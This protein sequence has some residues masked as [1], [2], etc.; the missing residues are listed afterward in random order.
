M[1]TGRIIEL[2]CR[3]ERGGSKKDVG[4]VDHGTAVVA[5][6]LLVRR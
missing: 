5:K 6:C 1:G 2:I 3:T 4:H